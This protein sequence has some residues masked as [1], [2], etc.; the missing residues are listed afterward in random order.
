VS[1]ERGPV[2]DFPQN[3]LGPQAARVVASLTA[4]S[5]HAAYDASLPVLLVFEENDPSRP[6]I[7]DIVIEQPS[8]AVR[9]NE[10]AA[11]PAASG[12]LPQADTASAAAWMGTILCVE[13]DV[14]RVQRHDDG[15][16]VEA[17]TATVLRNLRDPVIALSS[18]SGAVIVGQA[19]SSV[20]IESQDALGADV[21]LKG[22]R[23]T[24]E[25]DTELVLRSGT[26][27]IRLD[28]RG[29]AVTTAESIVSRARGTNKVQGGSV[30]LN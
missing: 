29:K 12:P 30:H 9:R 18:S 24:I 8:A 13:N 16:I 1:L 15:S 6:V 2:V 23:V 19:Y 21:V 20:P 26:C 4:D 28:A 27:V 7:I 3:P 22:S 11:I 5:I 25:A 14:V 10:V 17:A